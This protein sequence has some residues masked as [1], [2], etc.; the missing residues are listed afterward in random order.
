MKGDEELPA[1]NFPLG[2]CEGDCDNDGECQAG[3]TCQQRSGNEDVPGCIGTAVSGEDYCRY[4]S[5]V[6]T[7][8]NGSPIEAF[9]LGLCEGDCDGDGDCAVRCSF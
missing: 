2:L 3:L 4:P 1:I 8:D 6:L 7:G 9:P 5:L